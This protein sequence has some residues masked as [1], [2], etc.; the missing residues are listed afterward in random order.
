[1][2]SVEYPDTSGQPETV[3]F[4][5]VMYRLM[6]G[7]RRYYLSQSTSNVGG[8]NIPPRNHLTTVCLHDSMNISNKPPGW[9]G[10]D[11]TGVVR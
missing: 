7:K 1:M 6:G 3:E 8:A 10:R 5:G 2:T 4:L 9:A 11:A